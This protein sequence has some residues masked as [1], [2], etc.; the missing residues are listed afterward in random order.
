MYWFVSYIT[1]D[2]YH[3]HIDICAGGAGRA[4][5]EGGLAAHPARAPAGAQRLEPGVAL[6]V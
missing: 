1:D 5:A 3:I 2:S 6:L 4:A